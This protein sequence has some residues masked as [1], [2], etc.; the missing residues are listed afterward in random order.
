MSVRP[1]WVESLSSAD[2]AEA[3]ALR[4][5]LQ[6]VGSGFEFAVHRVAADVDSVGEAHHRAVLRLLCD[7]ITA[8]AEHYRQE[9]IA[10]DPSVAAAF[11]SPLKFD[12]GAARATP[13]DAAAVIAAESFAPLHRIAHTRD[14]ATVSWFEWFCA[15]F[16]DPPYRL[17]VADE[18]E[19]AQLF[20]R[21]CPC[22][23]LLPGEGIVA[24]D[25]VGDPEREPERSMWS[26]YFDE[27]K[28]WW[29][30]WC[31]TVWNPRRRTLAAMIASQTD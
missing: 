29:G 3:V 19:R 9:V 6:R 18:T 21:F 17:Q 14:P 11:G 31:L 30:I 1:H 13:L 27:G 15:A 20:P 22:T 7:E 24:L 12:V 5:T 4:K 23:G 2:E 28:E 25:W 8:A 26:D 16:G 10:R